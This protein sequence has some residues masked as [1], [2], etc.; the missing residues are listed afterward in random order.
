MRSLTPLEW[1]E[2]FGRT[3]ERESVGAACGE[4]VNVPPAVGSVAT[5]GEA[6]EAGTGHAVL[7]PG[8]DP[9]APDHDEELFVSENRCV[10]RERQAP[11]EPTRDSSLW[12]R[13]ASSTPSNAQITAMYRWTLYTGRTI[14]SQPPSVSWLPQRV[15]IPSGTLA[16]VLES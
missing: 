3:L 16:R 1:F 7:F 10:L 11:R 2:P 6:E 14:A 5:G 15:D 8:I 12:S 9:S 4:S 13:R